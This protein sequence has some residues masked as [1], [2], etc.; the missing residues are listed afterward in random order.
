MQLRWI[1]KAGE[2]G[3]FNRKKRQKREFRLKSGRKSWKNLTMKKTEFY[4]GD[5]A[6]KRESPAKSGRV[7][8]YEDGTDPGVQPG[9]FSAKA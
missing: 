4:A 7:G 6:Q 3:R 5:S 2:N 8:I 1:Q 9:F